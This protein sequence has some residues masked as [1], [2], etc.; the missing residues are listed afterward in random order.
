M[1][2]ALVCT[3]HDVRSCVLNAQMF[4]NM[5]SS[6]ALNHTNDYIPT[7]NRYTSNR[8]TVAGH[9]EKRKIE[10]TDWIEVVKQMIEKESK[11]NDRTVCENEREHKSSNRQPNRNR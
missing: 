7:Y 6:H 1:D 2:N 11:S 3:M 5:I 10:A 8:N 9:M 4:A